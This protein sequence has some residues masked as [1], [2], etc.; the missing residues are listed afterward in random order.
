MAPLSHLRLR[1]QTLAA[2]GGVCACC[3]EANAAFLALDHIHGGGHQDRKTR[4]ARRLY[5]E[6][7]DTG[8]PLGDYQVLCHNCNVAKRTGPACPCAT[9]RQTIAEALEA[10]PSRTRARGERV[11]LAKL[12]AYKVRQL[13]AL[14][15][16]GV[17][18]AALGWMFGVS[19]QSARRAGLGRTWAHVPGEVLQSQP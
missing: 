19:P 18:W 12:T 14:A 6:L 7:R 16:Q 9:G 4:D 13:R 1:L 10:I 3:G 11:T 15:A 2:Y 8:F 5:R 17:S